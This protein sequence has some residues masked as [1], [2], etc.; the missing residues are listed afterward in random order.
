MGLGWYNKQVHAQGPP[1]P[2]STHV[3]SRVRAR[4]SLS[5]SVQAN[6]THLNTCSSEQLPMPLRAHTRLPQLAHDAPEL[7]RTCIRPN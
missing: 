4:A 7:R 1:R 6:T 2:A 3:N 5:T